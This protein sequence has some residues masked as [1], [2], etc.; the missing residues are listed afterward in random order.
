MSMNNKK[1]S[2]ALVKTTLS[3][4]T[5]EALKSRILDQELAPGA[6]LNIDSL[7]KELEVSSSPIREALARLEA[8]RLIVSELYSG[9]SVAPQPTLAHLHCL[10]DF[11]IVVEGYCARIGAN[12]KSPETVE[13]L[14]QLVDQMAKT[15]LLGTRY[16][17]YRKFIQADAQFH[18]A[19]VDSAHNEVMS[20][21]Y[22]SKHAILLQS[23]LYLNREGGSTSS[24]TV[25]G[26]HRKILQAYREG[27]GQAAQAA[28]SEHLE[29]GRE[30]LL[31]RSTGS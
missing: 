5:Y 30:R 11:R 22:A 23:R 27:D 28:I 24:E 4:Q 16:H 10:L 2:R 15:K 19:I 14:E 25:Q 18:Q 12:A 29:K 17:E 6:R 8:E 26:E 13:T 7:S 31:S 9:Y 21:V 3:E 1:N 20:D